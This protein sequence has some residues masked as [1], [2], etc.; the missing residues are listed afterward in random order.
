MSHPGSTPRPPDYWKEPHQDLFLPGGFKL[1]SRCS[2]N[3]EGV[4]IRGQELI[5]ALEPEPSTGLG[6][7]TPKGV[8]ELEGLV[9][10][11]IKRI[12]LN[13]MRSWTWRILISNNNSDNSFLNAYNMS[14]AMPSTQQESHLI[15]AT[16]W[17][18]YYYS[19]DT[20]GKLKLKGIR[21]L[22]QIPQLLSEGSGLDLG[23]KPRAV[24]LWDHWVTTRYSLRAPVDFGKALVLMSASEGLLGKITMF[25]I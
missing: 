9:T 15:F 14:D 11:A 10:S 6:C 7:V 21:N 23:L 13:L 24:W 19:Q 16:L 4:W 5:R 20:A 1:A 17:S 22:P 25:P 8:T 3:S 18:M 2:N 12:I